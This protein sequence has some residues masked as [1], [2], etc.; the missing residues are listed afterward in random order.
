MEGNIKIRIAQNRHKMKA[1]DVIAA[2][3]SKIKL[4]FH[5]ELNQECTTFTIDMLTLVVPAILKDKEKRLIT[6]AIE[7]V[8]ISS[9][10]ILLEAPEVVLKFYTQHSSNLFNKEGPEL[11]KSYTCVVLDVEDTSFTST[12]MEVKQ[13]TYTMKT[14]VFSQYGGIS[15]DLFGLFTCLF[16]KEVT[17]H[18]KKKHPFDYMKP[19]HNF[20]LQLEHIQGDEKVKIRIPWKWFDRYKHTKGTSIIKAIKKSTFSSDVEFVSDKVKISNEL[21]KEK[22]VNLTTY[23]YQ[24]LAKILDESVSEIGVLYIV[25]EHIDNMFVND[26][27]KRYPNFTIFAEDPKDVILK[28]AIMFWNE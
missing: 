18:L 27:K 16:T 19:L 23:R 2:F 13:H 12:V 9:N 21:F 6:K 1:V 4:K 15:E 26:L 17:Q 22:F 28:G 20:Q 11:K 7:M 24:V 3:I 25:G 10:F 14:T 5:T 8:G